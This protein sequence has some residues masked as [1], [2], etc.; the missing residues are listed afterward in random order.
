MPKSGAKQKNNIEQPA[1][2]LLLLA[3]SHEPF[4][5]RIE[6]F[7]NEHGIKPTLI[8]NPNMSLDEIALSI[9][10]AAYDLHKIMEEFKL[11]RSNSMQD[12][13][14]KYIVYNE[15]HTN[16]MARYKIVVNPMVEINK[17]TNKTLKHSRSVSLVTFARLTPTEERQALKELKDMQNFAL[18]PAVLKNGQNLK[19]IRL[20]LEI[21]DALKASVLPH[22]EKQYT[23]WMTDVANKN[24]LAGK[25]PKR[26]L[27]EIIKKNPHGVKKVKVGYT[28]KDV[29]KKILGTKQ[30]DST[31]RQKLRR[32]KKTRKQFLG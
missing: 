1:T 32:L 19:K 10:K 26:E 5:K 21:E 6:E 17:K 23:S 28:S 29:A 13:L 20:D 16:A 27:D 11:P 12:H 2:G 25:I 14:W 30:K 4:L 18:H 9:E 22:T 7:R 3:L 8:F 24:Y 15:L 31:I